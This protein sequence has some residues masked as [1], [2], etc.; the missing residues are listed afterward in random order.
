M[1]LKIKNRVVLEYLSAGLI[2]GIFFPILST[3]IEMMNHQTPITFASFIR[4]QQHNTLL[5][6]ID[7]ALPIFT[8]FGYQIGVR[9]QKLINQANNLEETVNKRSEEIIRQKLFY[10]ALVKSSP[11]AIASSV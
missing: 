7:L 10:E 1:A 11:L 5:W 8:F 9:Q 3:W 6:I 2:L 4:A